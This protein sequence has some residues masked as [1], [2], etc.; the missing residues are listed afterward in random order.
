MVNSIWIL[1]FH[2]NSGILMVETESK[3]SKKYKTE[4][5]EASGY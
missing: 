4:F 2:K 3:T 5:L 1:G